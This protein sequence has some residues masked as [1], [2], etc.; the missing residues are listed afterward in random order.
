MVFYHE[1]DLPPFI[2]KMKGGLPV[3]GDGVVQMQ[4]LSSWS[5]DPKQ[6]VSFSNLTFSESSTQAS[7]VVGGRIPASRI[8]SIGGDGFGAFSESELIVLGNGDKMTY[9]INKPVA[10]GT[11]KYKVISAGRS[12]AEDLVLKTMF[13]SPSGVAS[14]LLKVAATPKETLAVHA[15]KKPTAWGPG[16]TKASVATVEK[17]IHDLE[18]QAWDWGHDMLANAPATGKTLGEDVVEYII[19]EHGG[20]VTLN[21]I[22]DALE[23][24]AGYPGQQYFKAMKKWANAATKHPPA[25]SAE[26]LID[27]VVK[28]LE[29]PEPS[30]IAKAVTMAPKA[31]AYEWATEYDNLKEML[32]YGKTPTG[33]INKGMDT[34]FGL[35]NAH[36]F[37][38]G[39]T[40]TPKG[41]EK[42]F[43]DVGVWD[44]WVK[45][46]KLSGKDVFNL[47]KWYYG[48]EWD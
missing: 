17:K 29:V 15:A 13:S 3:V 31:K 47:I 11:S 42:V 9:F 23:Y 16:K 7:M 14:E 46:A 30:S 5:L 45:L 37:D 25:K 12:D 22:K 24:K 39:L 8:L 2:A 33:K 32:S 19:K 44:Q 41:V 20:T 40:F 43:R 38:E 28:F 4:P 27:Q 36:L 6:G 1:K 48:A 35:K 10:F 21:S 26:F 18:N 34:L